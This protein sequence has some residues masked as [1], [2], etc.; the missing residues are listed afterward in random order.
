MKFNLH[1]HTKRCGHAKGEDEEY[2]LAAIDAGYEMIG[3]S[4]HAPFVFP[5]PNHK[6]GFRIQLNKAQDY[7]DSIRALQ[8]KY[9]DKIDIKLGYELEWY[10]ELM[11]TELKYLSQFNYDYLILGQHFIGNEYEPW[12]KYC[13]DKTD[14]VVTLD[15]YIAQLLLGAKSGNFTYV[16]HPDVINFTGDREL[17]KRKMR[18]MVEE[19]KKINIPLEYNF[20]G[21][22]TDRHYPNDDFWSIVA[23]VGNPVVIGLDAH[24]TY[25]YGDERLEPMVAHMKEL[26]LNIIDEIELIKK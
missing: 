7:A 23:E 18:Y 14:S 4:D 11:D 10:P 8:E 12:A 2:V 21:Y 16:C 22:Y 5:D 17:Y 3:F 15:K 26:G 1:T 20:Y 9:K 25:V 13:G 6:S 24:F 19:L